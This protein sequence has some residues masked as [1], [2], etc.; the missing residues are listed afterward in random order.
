MYHHRQNASREDAEVK[1]KRHRKRRSRRRRQRQ[2]YREEREDSD[3]PIP[4]VNRSTSEHQG[5]FPAIVERK[6]TPI[7]KQRKYKLFYSPLGK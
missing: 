1:R 2:N 7:V 5:K 6:G 4:T 3:S